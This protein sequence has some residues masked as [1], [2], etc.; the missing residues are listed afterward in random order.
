ML[1]IITG[2][3][4]SCIQGLREIGWSGG[5]I[6]GDILYVG[7]EQGRLVSVNTTNESRIWTEA[8]QGPS[9]SGG[10]F[11]CSPLTGG[12]GGSPS[13]AIYGTPAIEGNLV[14]VAG[15]N[16]RIYAYDRTSLM[17]RWRYPRDGYLKP[18]VGGIVV[19]D[20]KLFFGD[21]GGY[22]HALDANTGDRVW[23][24]T[25]EEDKKDREKIWATPAV[26]NG[27]VYIGSYNKKLY[28]IDAATGT[29]KWDF[30]TEGSVIA[31][32][33]V[34]DGTIYAGSLDRNLWL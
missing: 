32:V 1:A 17:E 11:G 25:T 24:F 13:V 5:A 2:V 29:K 18:I 14:Y 9:S 12:C 23:E 19:A 3:G 31:Q 26:S 15:Y 33:L 16:G 22:V 34:M 28:A 27:T 4:M 7:N 10:L 8:L 6:V 21:S 30:L 20:G